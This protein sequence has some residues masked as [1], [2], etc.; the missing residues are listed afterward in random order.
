MSSILY[1]AMV[2]V[3]SLWS[4][5]EGWSLHVILQL[6]PYPVQWSSYLQVSILL[7][8][9]LHLIASSE[10]DCFLGCAYPKE[11]LSNDCHALE[12]RPS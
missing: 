4:I 6:L 12:L 3:G 9:M 1:G 5:L 11:L 10:L 2:S 7:Q 8:T